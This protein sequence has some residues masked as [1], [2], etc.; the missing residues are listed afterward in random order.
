MTWR[1]LLLLLL[2]AAPPFIGCNGGVQHPEPNKPNSKDYCAKRDKMENNC[3]ACSSQP[4]C[5]WCEQPVAGAASCQPGTATESSADCKSGWAFSSEDCAAPPPP[6]PS[7]RA[8]FDT[9][10]EIARP[11]GATAPVP[12]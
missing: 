4:G 5:G 6:P 8:S 11:P 3:M 9:D 10:E 12:L 2:L 7:A 1:P